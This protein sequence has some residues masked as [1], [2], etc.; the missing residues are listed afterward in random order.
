MAGRV[1]TPQKRAQ[2]LRRARLMT[3]GLR[4]ES[5][6]SWIVPDSGDTYRCEV[7]DRFGRPMPV[8]AFD[9]ARKIIRDWEVTLLVRYINEDGQEAI[10]EQEII[11]RQIRLNEPTEFLKEQRAQLASEVTGQ[12]L[13]RGWVAIALN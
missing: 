1:T 12:I 7:A 11:F 6:E 2:V 4:L 5:W 3:K 9:L 8:E 10:D 13:D